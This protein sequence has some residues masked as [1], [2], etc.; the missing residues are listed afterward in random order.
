M[1]A[2]KGLSCVRR[3]HHSMSLRPQT[4]TSIP[5]PKIRTLLSG[6][7]LATSVAPLAAVT[8]NQFNIP[9][10]EN[11]DGLATATDS[12]VPAGWA[13]TETGTSAN[14]TLNTLLS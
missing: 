6:L 8:L 12:V 11:F 4:S 13:F 3:L 10:T 2:A 9:F 1:Q 5:M 7:L 14:T